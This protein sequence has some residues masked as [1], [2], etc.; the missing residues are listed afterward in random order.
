MVYICLFVFMVACCDNI[1][2]SLEIAVIFWKLNVHVTK[3]LV[4]RVVTISQQ[5][6]LNDWSLSGH[7]MV[8]DGGNSDIT[9]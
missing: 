1:Q 7:C 6:K 5:H 9:W 2:I 8:E 4:Q 3:K